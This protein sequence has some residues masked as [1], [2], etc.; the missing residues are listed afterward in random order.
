MPDLS[1]EV[2]TRTDWESA[3]CNNVCTEESEV[4]EVQMLEEEGFPMRERGP[5]GNS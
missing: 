2:G 3:E 4:V 5:E 1:A